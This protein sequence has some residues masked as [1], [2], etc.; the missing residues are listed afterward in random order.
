MN[1]PHAT[2]CWL[3]GDSDRVANDSPKLIPA[4][5]LAH[6][7]A[8]KSN[9]SRTQ[10]LCSALLIL[11]IVLTI[12]IGI[13]LAVQEPGS[14]IAYAIFVGPAYLATGVRALHGM[15]TDRQPKASSLLLTF[16]FSAVFTTMAV[17]LF[18]IASVIAFFVWCLS[19]L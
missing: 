7:P 4:G 14:L 19:Q 18:V 5:E 15:A 13:G 6:D 9:Q 2:T 16:L 8:F 17:V 11:C 3:C 12:L 1:P 10:T